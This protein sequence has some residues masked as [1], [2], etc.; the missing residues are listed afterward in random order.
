MQDKGLISFFCMQQ[1]YEFDGAPFPSIA[2]KEI[3]GK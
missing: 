2:S 1:P 3:Y